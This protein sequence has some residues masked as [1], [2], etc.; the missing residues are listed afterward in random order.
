MQLEGSLN[1]A[2]H[3]KISI[4]ILLHVF[5]VLVLMFVFI[6]IF[7][8]MI[9]L[10]ASFVYL[11]SCHMYHTVSHLFMVYHVIKSQSALS[12]K[13]TFLV[14]IP[15]PQNLAFRPR[16][17]WFDEVKFGI[18]SKAAGHVQA[19]GWPQLLCLKILLSF[20]FISPT[21]HYHD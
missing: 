13:S 3:K 21:I 17:T 1:L 8:K 4:T 20:F 19:Q 14:L 15:H 18:F 5:R 16:P 12:H 11:I 10:F 6:V 2:F 7:V 9:S